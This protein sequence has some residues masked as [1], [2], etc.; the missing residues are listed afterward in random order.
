MAA[1]LDQIQNAGNREETQKRGD[2]GDPPD[3]LVVVEGE[4]HVAG[5]QILANCRQQ[6]S[7]SG[8]CQ[9][10]DDVL[11]GQP[12]DQGES[13][14]GQPEV[15]GRPEQQRN[16]RQQRGEEQEDERTEEPAGGRS[17]Q[18]SVESLLGVALLG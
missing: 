8:A 17:K 1:A 9:S 15:F 18:R 12:S 4:A 7:G 14:H 16:V 6:D 11:A 2:E 10:L 3:Q 5:D 13:G